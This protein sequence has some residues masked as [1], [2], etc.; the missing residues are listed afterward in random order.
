MEVEEVEEDARACPGAGANSGPV[1]YRGA[2]RER[3]ENMASA[4]DGGG[5]EVEVEVRES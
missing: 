2:A 1:R 3:V 4:G 5:A